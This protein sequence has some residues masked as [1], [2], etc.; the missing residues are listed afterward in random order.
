MA[1]SDDGGPQRRGLTARGQHLDASEGARV[2]S[3]GIIVAAAWLAA[4]ARFGQARRLLPRSLV[5]AQRRLAAAR[6]APIVLIGG[7]STPALPRDR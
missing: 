5:G 4:A 1:D 3:A 7:A 6:R 2:S